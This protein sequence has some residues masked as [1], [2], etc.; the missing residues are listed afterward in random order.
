MQTYRKTI[1]DTASDTAT[2]EVAGTVDLRVTDDLMCFTPA[3]ARKLARALKRAA[4]VAEGKP[5]KAPKAETKTGPAIYEDRDGDLWYR[6]PNGL[7]KCGVEFPEY[8]W[9]LAEL[10]ETYGP[11]GRVIS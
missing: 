6:G 1:S 2:V 5:A 8:N 3:Q 4:N 7:Y 10:E 9:T 11:G